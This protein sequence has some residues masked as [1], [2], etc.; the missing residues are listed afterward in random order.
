MAVDADVLPFQK[1]EMLRAI[2][3][4]FR[5]FLQTARED[6]DPILRAKRVL[7]RRLESDVIF[8]RKSSRDRFD[9]RAYH[10][11]VTQDRQRSTYVI[12]AAS[13]REW[14]KTE[15][16]TLRGIIAWL[17]EKRCLLAR[18]SRTT[19]TDDRPTDWAERTVVWPNR[20]STPVRSITFYDPFVR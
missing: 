1:K 15:P 4:C 19:K 6:S 11:Y 2:E 16:G 8:Q 20:K 17:E 5:D 12:R 18:E 14:L 3:R 7:R 10:G 13:L 9:A